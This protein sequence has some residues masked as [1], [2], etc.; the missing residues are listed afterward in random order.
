MDDGKRV[1][2]G[3]WGGGKKGD[4]KFVKGDLPIV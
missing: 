3:L 2:C 4:E 1:K